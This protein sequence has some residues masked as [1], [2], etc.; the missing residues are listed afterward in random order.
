MRHLLP[1]III[2]CLPS[3]TWASSLTLGVVG[4][5]YLGQP[6]GFSVSGLTPGEK[7]R[8]SV[9]EDAGD[10]VTLGSAKRNGAGEATVTGL[11]VDNASSVEVRV[12]TSL[13]ATASATFSIQALP[14]PSVAY[15]E[16]YA[17]C[18]DDLDGGSPTDTGSDLEPPVPG[19][20]DLGSIL[21]EA[22]FDEMFPHQ[23]DSACS[24]SLLT[25]QALLDAAAG[26]PT[27]GAEGTD[28]QRR[29]EITA[30][31]ANS[32]HETTGGWAT[33]PDGP[34]AWGLCFTE[35]IGCEFGGSPEPGRSSRPCRPSGAGAARLGCAG[36]R[37][38]RRALA[39]G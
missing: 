15:A 14:D 8:L 28:E 34:Y 26:W 3:S 4:E 2:T 10:I 24:G 17:A 30:F 35:E 19:T 27:F 13:G 6:V 22:M 7:L 23:D 31:L 25:Y 36:D 5:L 38:T 18:L 21:T 33:A 39:A 29:Q 20:G 37:R 16:G 9:I 1:L 11:L 32:S 12:Q